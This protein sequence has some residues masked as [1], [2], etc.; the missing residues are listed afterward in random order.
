MKT[1][2]EFGTVK[3]INHYESTLN[4]RLCIIVTT[5]IKQNRQI[6]LKMCN[7]IPN[8]SD[9]ITL[10]SINYCTTFRILQQVVKD[11]LVEQLL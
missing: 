11:S 1:R 5:P 3:Q 10:K 8:N 2:K 9:D 4:N 7:E 6:Y